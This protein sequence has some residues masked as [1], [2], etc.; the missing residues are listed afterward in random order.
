[1]LANNI[2]N[3]AVD[4]TPPTTVIARPHEG[5]FHVLN[6][7]YSVLFFLAVSE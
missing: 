7:I 3:D 6:A 2:A 4:V 1:M 5:I